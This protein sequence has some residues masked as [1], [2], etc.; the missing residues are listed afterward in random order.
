MS[1]NEAVPD[2]VAARARQ[3]RGISNEEIYRM[4]SR[5][6]AARGASGE[7]LVDVGCGTGT[8]ASFVRPR[9]RR[10]VGVDAVAYEGFPADSQFH[11]LDL[12]TGRVPLPDGY[13]D[14][15]T[16]V[17]VIEHLEN[18]RAFVRELARLVRPG[19][20]VAVSTPNQLSLLSLLS[21]V[22]KRRFAHFQDAHYPAHLTALLEVDLRRIAAECGLQEVGI[23]YS[24]HGRVPLTPTHYPRLLTGGFPRLLSDN[25]VLVGRR[26][27]Q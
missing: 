12:D 16:A 21:L 18:P 7:V 13:A 23:E 24:R 15:V 1:L 11:L 2:T 10:Y 20:W 26:G 19:G 17:E 25:L 9:F 6:L 3:S 22:V 5:A 8:L 14:A 4:V 27:P